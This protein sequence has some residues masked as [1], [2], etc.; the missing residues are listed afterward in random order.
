MPKI[1]TRKGIAK[2]F[3]ITGRGKI[4]YTRAGRRHLL[5]GKSRKR[6]RKLGKPDQLSSADERKI[7]SGLPYAS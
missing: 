4:M 5:T 7:K 6:M 1:K 3:R 2:R